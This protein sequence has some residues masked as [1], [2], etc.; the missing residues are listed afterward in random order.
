MKKNKMALLAAVMSFILTGCGIS[1]ANEEDTS[2]QDAVTTSANV[3]TEEKTEKNSETKTVNTA[4]KTEET[5]E[6]VTASVTKVMNVSEM[7]SS[8]DYEVGYDKNESAVITLNGNSAECT[9]EA[10]EISGSSVKITA[11]GTY[12]LSGTLSDGSVIIEAGKDD[13]IQLVLDGAKVNSKTSA[14]I[15]IIQADKV[16]ITTAA[17]TENILSNGGEFIAVDDNN[18][19][20]VIFSKDDLTLNGQGSVTVKSPAGHGIVSKDDLRITSGVYE[21]TSEGH[22]LSG[23]DCVK[24]AGGSFSVTSGKDGIHADNSDDDSLGYAFISGGT[25]II[26]SEGDGISASGNLQIEGGDF[27]V[28]TAEGS[29]FVTH[30]SNNDWMQRGNKSI[31]DRVY[32][33]NITSD[34]NMINGAAPTPPAAPSENAASDSSSEDTVST[35]GLKASGQL[36][37]NGG[38][39]NIDSADDSVHSNSD[40]TIHGGEFELS[41]GDDAIHADKTVKIEERSV[42]NIVKCYEGIEAA[43]VQIDGGRISINSSDDGINAAQKVSGLECSVE[44]NGGDITI[45]MDAG[46]TDAIDSNGSIYVNGGNINITAQSAFDYVNSGELNGGTV[47]VNGELI[48]E[49]PA[50]MFGFGGNGGMMIN[51]GSAEGG[52]PNV[53]PEGAPEIPDGRFGGRFGQQAEQT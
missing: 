25:Y 14:A 2:K 45:V 20:A 49:M 1:A 5:A 46:D 18:I 30:V 29:S 9:S 41:T 13:K 33:N 42:I 19:D 51:P 12:I 35:K 28:K 40:I 44:I 17:D 53:I 6:K 38:T 47:Y 22:G 23:K 11:E 7:F 32:G 31:R 37:I 15:Y 10:V 8:R 21:I 36:I 48:N 43:Y 27:T 50:S 24:I 34:G 16:F 3:I 39:F 26:N 52:F 4:A